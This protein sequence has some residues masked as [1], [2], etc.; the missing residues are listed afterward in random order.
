MESKYLLSKKILEDSDFVGLN[1]VVA[2]KEE[3]TAYIIIPHFYK[4]NI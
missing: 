4:S 2:F 1:L 3:K